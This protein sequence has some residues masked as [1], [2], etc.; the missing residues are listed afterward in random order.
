MEESA[1]KT[2]KLTSHCCWFC[3]CYTLL[4]LSLF[5]QATVELT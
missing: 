5:F 4:L 1:E 2:L 3:S